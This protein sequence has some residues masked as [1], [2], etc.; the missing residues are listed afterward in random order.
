[1]ADSMKCSNC[2]ARFD[3]PSR[4]PATPASGGAV[5]ARCPRCAA[6]VA[7]PRAELTPIKNDEV[8]RPARPPR[9]KQPSA[10][11]LEPAPGE[12]PTVPLT[13][14]LGPS[15][16]A[17]PEPWTV[18]YADDDDRE[19]TEDELIGALERGEITPDT[20]VWRD[21]MDDWLPISSVPELAGPLRRAMDAAARGAESSDE[22]AAPVSLEPESLPS[23]AISAIP[24]PGPRAL[25][26]GTLFMDGPKRPP[27]PAPRAPRA[28][29]APAAPKGASDAK[30][31]PGPP[32]RAKM[33]TAPGIGPRA[34][35]KP[36]T[37]A[38][39]P[40]PELSANAEGEPSSSELPTL[41]SLASPK[42]PSRSKPDEDAGFDLLSLGSPSGGIAGLE[43]RPPTFGAE[44][45]VTSLDAPPV[46]PS[47]GIDEVTIELPPRAEGLVES[48]AAKRDVG[49]AAR[50]PATE[51]TTEKR[52]SPLPWLALA[53]AA[54]FAVYWFVLRAPA[55]EPAP[56]P[57]AAA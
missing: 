24:E 56:A 47:D 37:P 11:R 23:D 16:P 30:Q 4:G 44:P 34:L 5:L 45:L 41:T 19:L 40:I 35:P 2:G 13:F 50:A 12:T 25:S 21:G 10:P 15:A 52:K 55:P 36:P 46:E 57:T 38:K 18:S 28:A 8:A 49:G 1:M 7:S 22:E 20:I 14:G 9:P 51:P 31:P 17:E 43:L 27:V 42:P 54:A 48:A 3:A 6:K 26:A 29:S 33:D 53:A 32:P 39:R